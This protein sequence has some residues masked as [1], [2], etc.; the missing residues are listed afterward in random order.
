MKKNLIKNKPAFTLIEILISMSIFILIFTIVMLNYRQGENNNI[1]RLQAF[2]I[3]D[4][5]RDVQNMAMTGK[6]ID[7]FVPDAYGIF[8]DKASRNII[9]YGDKNGD[10]VFKKDEDPIYSKNILQNNINFSKYTLSCDGNIISSNL[11]IVFIPP[12]PTVLINNN[13]DCTS[14]IISI[15]STT[16]SGNWHI[17]FDAVSGKVWSDFSN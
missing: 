2:D 13:P 7:N 16:S 11:N 14:L 8:L 6:E 17:Y 4:S 9:I 15:D 10:Y 12:G 3:E 5:I 1:F